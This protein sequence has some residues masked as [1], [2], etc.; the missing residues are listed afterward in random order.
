ML[1]EGPSFGNAI[2]RKLGVFDQKLEGN[3]STFTNVLIDI[4]ESKAIMIN[5]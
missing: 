4:R 1:F 5:Q 2:S 3:H